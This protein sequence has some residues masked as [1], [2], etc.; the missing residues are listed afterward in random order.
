MRQDLHYAFRQLLRNPGFSMVAA[1]TLGLGI[2][3]NTIIATLLNTLFFQPLPVPAPDRLVAVY[4]ADFSHGRYGTSSHPDYLDMAQ[5]IPSL[6]GLTGMSLQPTS[7]SS[8]GADSRRILL[9]V[10]AGDYFGVLRVPLLLGRGF[11]PDEI[12]PGGGPAVVLSHALWSTAF[13]SDA[14]IIGRSVRLGG[15]PFTVVGVAAAGYSG[16]LRGVTEGAWVPIAADPLLRPGSEEFTSRGSRGTL[17]YG[18]LRP[19][20]RVESAQAEATVL[21]ARM[22]AEYPDSWRNIQGTGRAITVLPES[23]VRVLPMIRGQVLGVGALFAVVVGIVLLITCANLANLVMARTGARGREFAVRLSLGA[24]R[25][26]LVRQLLVENVVLGAVGGLA[27]L[28]LSAWITG[29]ASQYRPPLPIPIALDLHPDIRV[30]LF[31]ALLALLAGVLVGIAPALQASRLSLAPVLKDASPSGGSHRSRMRDAFVVM[32]VGLSLVLLIG[33]GLFLRSL[34]EAMAID[35]GFGARKALIVGVDLGLNG[36]PAARVR[37]FQSDLRERVQ[38]LSG[39][40]AVAYASMLP[41]SMD[42]GRQNLTIDGYRAAEGEDMEIF[43]NSVSD[44]YFE[45]MGLPLAKGRAFTAADREG[46]P[47]VVIVNESFVRRY[48]PG[49]DGLGRRLSLSGP[50]GP[51]LEVVGVARD[52][53][54]QSLYEDPKPYFYRPLGQEIED[55]FT[56][57]ARTSLDPATLSGPV[58]EAIRALDPSLPLDGVSTLE[59]HIDLSLL[60]ARIA[61]IVLGFLG[62]LGLVLAS[63]GVAGVVAYGVTQRV[64]EIG[65]R[66]AL[67]ARSGE[68]VRL[69]VRDGLRLVAIGVGVGVAIAL[70]LAMLVRRFLYG[71]SPLD[72]AAFGGAIAVF[73]LV[74]VL[75]SWLPA[76]R[77]AAVDPM[78]ALRAE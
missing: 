51:F 53:K 33:A 38:T 14:G 60:P 9:G 31:V 7:V 59:D 10:V 76:R 72:P 42:G 11:S 36:Y 48:W 47:G 32:Q 52:S 67:G 28:A 5:G 66:I 27:G 16:L 20:A 64:R 46:A 43:S 62:L 63:L 41:L 4:T 18:R 39:V 26:R 2:A 25:P 58:R 49:S 30:F 21:A 17:L 45:T 1:V 15:V 77:A 29:L 70:P 74:A 6:E 65:I 35:P 75:A 34:K 40:E 3:G 71:L 55:R 50:D 19:G 23:Q 13:G 56:L 44:G 68:V 12:H 24:S 61:G 69:V 73:G 22:L 57:V 8:D 78:M 37:Q 54:Y